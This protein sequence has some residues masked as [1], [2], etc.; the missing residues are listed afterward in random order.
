M[1]KTDR[2]E[3]NWVLEQFIRKAKRKGEM[4]TEHENKIQESLRIR[5]EAEEQKLRE[6][7][8]QK[9]MMLDEA[10]AK[11]VQEDKEKQHRQQIELEERK[12]LVLSRC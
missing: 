10:L 11:K 1:S 7:E 8:K 4:T 2:T 12:K 9:Q 6:E 5:Q 3:K